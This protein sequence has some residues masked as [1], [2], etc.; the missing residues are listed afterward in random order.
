MKH[1]EANN[2]GVALLIKRH[3]R[4]HGV[5]AAI[6]AGHQQLGLCAW[7]ALLHLC[8]QKKL[9][10]SG[11]PPREQENKCLRNLLQCH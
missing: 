8:T 7:E 4:V 6:V 9:A 11:A 2:I 3:E 5:C 10:S 1:L